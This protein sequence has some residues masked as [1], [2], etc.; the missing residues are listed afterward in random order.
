[1]VIFTTCCSGRLFGPHEVFAFQIQR[2]RCCTKPLARQPYSNSNCI[3]ICI[4]L[5]QLQLGFLFSGR[6]VTRIPDASRLQTCT[7]RADRNIRSTVD[8]STRAKPGVHIEAFG[9]SRKGGRPRFRSRATPVAVYFQHWHRS[10]RAN[11]RQRCWMFRHFG[12]DLRRL[13]PFDTKRDGAALGRKRSWRLRAE[14][15]SQP[16]FPPRLAPSREETAGPRR[17]PL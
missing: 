13:C 14:G 6:S 7:A 4:R 2:L 3:C 8:R 16:P 10:T 5:C 1:L 17:T 12:T 9:L 15:Q 11:A